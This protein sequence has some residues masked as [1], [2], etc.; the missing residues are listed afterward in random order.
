MN[1]NFVRGGGGGGGGGGGEGG[2][3]RQ[4]TPRH[5]CINLLQVISRDFQ[6]RLRKVL[7]R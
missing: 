5:S 3:R 2:V 7:V 6:Q 1:F 4:E